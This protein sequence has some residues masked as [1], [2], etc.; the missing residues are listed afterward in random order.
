MRN[1][2]KTKIIC[3]STPFFKLAFFLTLPLA[4]FRSVRNFVIDLRLMPATS[5]ATGLHWQVS[6]ATSLTNVRVEM[7][8]ES[9]NNHQ[10]DFYAVVYNGKRITNVL[11]GSSWKMAG[12]VM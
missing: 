9:G 2:T 11:Q 6:Q 1:G 8:R 4:S 3:F 7:S 10:G 12:R 5:K